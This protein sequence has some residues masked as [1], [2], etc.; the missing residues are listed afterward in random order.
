MRNASSI[1]CWIRL[2]DS[3]FV[4]ARDKIL[5][6]RFNVSDC[7]SIL[8]LT[9]KYKSMPAQTLKTEETRITEEP[10]DEVVVNEVI[11]LDGPLAATANELCASVF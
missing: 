1:G 4:Y 3:A 9:C 10:N 2:I 5:I 11:C 6:I 8:T 7:L